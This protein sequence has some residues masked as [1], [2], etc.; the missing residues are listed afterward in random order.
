MLG[1]GRACNLIGAGG[2]EAD[3]GPFGAACDK[4]WGEGGIGGTKSAGHNG[5]L[6]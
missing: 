2:A 1:L 6:R 4:V 5:E 3:A